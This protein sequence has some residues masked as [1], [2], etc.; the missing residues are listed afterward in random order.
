MPTALVLLAEGAEEM[1]VVILVDVLRRGGI[2][3]T[4]AG[5]DGPEPVRC[6]RGVLLTPD[7]GLADAP[8]DPDVLVLPGGAGGAERLAASEEVGTRLRARQETGRL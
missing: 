7:V 1:E 3:V 5:L 8:A 6:S 2:E 4:L